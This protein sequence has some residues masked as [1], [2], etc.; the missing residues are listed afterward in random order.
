MLVDNNDE[1]TEKYE[2]FILFEDWIDD[3][4][5]D[6]GKLHEN[7]KIAHDRIHELEAVRDRNKNRIHEL[8]DEIKRLSQ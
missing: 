1:S 2:S 6:N 7:L 3:L 4:L 8:E 5:V